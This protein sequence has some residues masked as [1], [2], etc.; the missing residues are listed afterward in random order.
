M[1]VVDNVS[2]GGTLVGMYWVRWVGNAS[3]GRNSAGAQAFRKIIA[4]PGLIVVE[5]RR[6]DV[7]EGGSYRKPKKSG[8]KL[9]VRIPGETGYFSLDQF[10]WHGDYTPTK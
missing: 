1:A 8:S 4:T 7:M 5:V 2:F 6:F 9:A 3:I 10:E